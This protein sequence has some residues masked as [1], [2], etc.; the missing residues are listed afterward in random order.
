MLL[1]PYVFLIIVFMSMKTFALN[2]RNP[3]KK[4]MKLSRVLSLDMKYQRPHVNMANTIVS[5]SPM[6]SISNYDIKLPV[7]LMMA[8]CLFTSTCAHAYDEKTEGKGSKAFELCLSKCIYAETRP[9]PINASVERLSVTKGRSEIIFDC[10]AK[11]AVS[12]QQLLLGQPKQEKIET[13]SKS[14]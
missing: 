7:I 6:T 14:D 3:M 13:S 1:Q 12:K 8:A 4:T 11:C 2:I 9:P 10:K 5:S